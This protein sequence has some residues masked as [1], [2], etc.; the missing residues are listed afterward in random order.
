MYKKKQTEPRILLLDS[1]DGDGDGDGD[2]EINIDCYRE[3]QWR[4]R[5]TTHASL[6]QKI[7]KHYLLISGLKIEKDGTVRNGLGQ[8]AFYTKNKRLL[9]RDT[10]RIKFGDQQTRDD[11]Y[12]LLNFKAPSDVTEV[13]TTDLGIKKNIAIEFFYV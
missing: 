12:T 11:I 6:I 3:H 10:L 1:T 4:S 5:I 9:A 8:E 13:A 7:K 2:G